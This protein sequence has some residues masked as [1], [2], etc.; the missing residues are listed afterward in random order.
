VPRDDIPTIPQQQ[1]HAHG[2]LYAK[3]IHALVPWAGYLALTVFANLM[4]GISHFSHPFG[5][6]MW[7]TAALTGLIGTGVAWFD[8]HMRRDRMSAV[9]TFIGPVTIEAGAL[10]T[11]IYLEAGFHPL[12]AIVWL[13]G[14]IGACLVWNLW[15]FGHARHD[16]SA[17]F[18]AA[19]QEA[20]LGPAR[21][22]IT[23]GRPKRER[24][25]ITAGRA[26]ARDPEAAPPLPRGPI[27]MPA[28]PS[29]PAA[30]ALAGDT[31]P[32]ARRD[33]ATLPRPAAPASARMPARTEAVVEWPA[34]A[35]T[36]EEAGEHLTRVEGAMHYPPGAISQ[37]PHG[38]DAAWSNVVISDPEVLAQS[39]PWPGP[40]FPGGTLADPFRLGMRQ[41]A[42]F[43][44]MYLLSL[45]H[46]RISGSTGTAKTMGGMWNFAAEGITRQG[47]ALFGMD[48]VKREQFFGPLKPAL[49]GLDIED[50]QILSRMLAFRRA[51]KARIDYL[52]SRGFTEWTLDCGLSLP[53]GWME[54]APSTLNRVAEMSRSRSGDQKFTVPDWAEGAKTDRSAGMMWVFSNQLGVTTE[55]PA[56]ARGQFTGTLC[57]GTADRKESKIGLSEQQYA[58]GAAPE[59]WRSRWPGKFY[60]D[61]PTMNEADIT[62][63]VRAWRWPDT[64]A[65]RA[66]AEQWEASQRPLDEVTA[67]AM[68]DEPALPD[69]YYPPASSAVKRGPGRPRKDGLP[70]QRRPDP[71]TRGP[72]PDASNVRQ[73]NFGQNG[74]DKRDSADEAEQVVAAQLAAW[75]SSAKT[76]FAFDELTKA[77]LWPPAGEGAGG[78]TG[79]ARPWGYNAVRSMCQLGYAEEL[80]GGGRKRWKILPSVTDWREEM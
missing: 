5:K 32:L 15:L 45:F 62:L 26:P 24:K 66:Y 78:S 29:Y 52:T 63:P 33:P 41:D 37:T 35:V 20:G 34:G 39:L 31:E 30:P 40:S 54:E 7:L 57:F 16:L 67:A 28:G 3:F 72:V 75:Y 1:R 42:A 47:F 17:R 65:L 76:V 68:A 9:G 55:I 44:W 8:W 53:V 25:A 74:T 56:V 11:V 51:R 59:K 6:W 61:V 46:L 69:S 50:E 71:R 49:H 21:L 60:A 22:M 4:L 18:G 12:L 10:M 70:P 80:P 2:E 64:H 27:A 43:F 36:P 19:A 23:R 38:A 48:P 77:G 79:R 73:V 58:M 14:G 13:F